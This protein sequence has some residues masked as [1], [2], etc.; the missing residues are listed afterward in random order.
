MN[1]KR[2]FGI[3]LASLGA[4]L[5]LTGLFNRVVDPF[6]YY[7][8]ITIDGFNSV[9][10]QFTNY[11]RHVK[12]VILR[13]TRPDAVI[14]SSSVLEAG[15]NPAHP[16]FTN[17]GTYH[18]YN[19]GM[20]A[21]WW[22]R[23]YCNLEY[24]LANTELKT[25][26]IG[27][28]PE[29]L[30][31]LDCSSRIKEMG[32]V[33]PSQLLFSFDAL[34]AS[35]KT[36]TQQ[37]KRPTHTLDGMLFYHRYQSG[38]IEASFAQEFYKYRI[39]S[40]GKAC[41]KPRSTDIPAWV[42]PDGEV[43]MRGLE[44]LLRQLVE[45]KVQVKLVI[46]PIHALWMELMLCD[47]LPKRWHLI[48]KMAKIVND[49]SQQGGDIEL[50]DFQGFSSGL[51]EKISN[52]QTR[53]WQDFGHFNYELGD[54]MLDLMYRRADPMDRWG[55]D[56]FGVRLTPESLPGRFTRFFQSRR[57]FINGNS[58]FIQDFEKFSQ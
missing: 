27:I 20:Q 17:D 1:G 23:V 55:D 10:T 9:K 34:K 57:E 50:W 30:P 19:F 53:Y 54:I 12:P 48:Y 44:K 52:N 42:P 11:E 32:A 31:S 24:A 3:C 47:D 45:R 2:Y 26:V 8:D 13:E 16:A 29:P 56:V 38:K 40:K 39:R 5:A 14:F 6:W 33:Q 41:P 51:V 49:A 18:G 4:L 25:V 58:G 35:L 21:A 28:S 37:A 46:Y 15:M 36:V 22:D 7:R 43:D